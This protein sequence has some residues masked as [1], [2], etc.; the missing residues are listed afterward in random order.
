MNG[1]ERG[2]WG[3][4]ESVWGGGDLKLR[5]NEEVILNFMILYIN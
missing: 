2:N 4:G 1:D 5:M 3:R